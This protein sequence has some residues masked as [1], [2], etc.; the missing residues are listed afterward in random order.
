MTQTMYATAPYGGVTV[1]DGAAMTLT[2]TGA[3]QL[4]LLGGSTGVW[5]SD[6]QF[7][8][9]L[10]WEFTNTATNAANDR[11]GFA[12]GATVG[13]VV[14]DFVCPVLPTDT[15]A[16]T[17]LTIRTG[18]ATS[19]GAV[20]GQVQLKQDGTLNALIGATSMPAPKKTDGTTTMSAIVPGTRYRLQF[21]LT[22]G[23]TATT[24]TAGMRISAYGADASTFLGQT[25][26]SGTASIALTAF[27]FADVGLGAF[28]TPRTLRLSNVRLIDG[29]ASWAG[30][31]TPATSPLTVTPVVTPS[32]QTKGSP[33]TC[34][35]NYTGGSGGTAS[36]RWD[37]G[38]GTS[39][40]AQASNSA[41]HSYNPT[42][43]SDFTITGYVDLT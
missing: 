22:Q 37:W 2:N 40:P 25:V 20:V 13:T 4:N 16:L 7:G 41:T 32:T 3:G 27:T 8:G 42:V 39:T 34:A 29:D 15:N 33:V 10:A 12:T 1:T 21:S 9:S 6:T 19:G 11:V 43:D 35:I 17:L 26:L 38:D 18:G 31:Y 14:Y 23:G 30:P 28:A 5:K 24:G 36:Y